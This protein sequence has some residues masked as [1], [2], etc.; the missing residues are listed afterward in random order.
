M[1]RDL[2][3]GLDLGT[4]A[5]KALAV[6]PVGRVVTDARADIELLQPA[7]GRAVIDADRYVDAA[8]A[9]LGVVAGQLDARRVA[10][11]AL[12]GAMHS[13]VPVDANDRPLTE[14]LTWADA[15]GQAQTEHLR[16]RTDTRGLHRR[17]GCPLRW[18]Y[19]APRL[20]YFREQ[21]SDI[22]AR[23]ARYVTLKD[24]VVHRLTGQWVADLGLMSTTGL[25]DLADR[26]F[27]DEALALADVGRDRLPR[28]CEPTAIIGPL[29]R[30]A[31]S[32]ARLLADLPVVAGSSDG[33]LA[34]LATLAGDQALA[35]TVG[36]SAAVRVN[37]PTPTVDDGE[38]T[39]CYL[40]AGDRYVRGGAI[41]NAGLLARWVA[42]RFYGD[43]P[44]DA[45]YATML[46]EAGD[47]A[48]GAAGVVMLPYLTGERTPIW[49]P[50]A[51]ATIHG[52]TL[53][54]TR[55]HIARAALEAVAFAVAELVDILDVRER[56]AAGVPLSGGIT[57][58]PIWC[59]ILADVLGAPLHVADV[60]DASAV[61]AAMVGHLAL[62]HV[63]TLDV[64]A[65][66]RPAGS[67]VTP[68]AAHATPYRD[69][70]ER[71][72]SLK[73]QLHAPCQH[74]RR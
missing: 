69:A 45:R 5:V 51:R 55:A 54:H 42:D 52:L 21:A 35:I 73:S 59:R 3:V 41:N 44:A 36:T 53:T 12:S 70:R 8:L 46:R 13:L 15:R 72:I 48:P 14:A 74:P 32:A 18:L 27:D 28:L 23:T 31:S 62:G 17:T 16:Q 67:T 61:G 22:D 30:E 34:N 40:I 64:G 43:A 11:L 7:P 47:V 65:R 68:T 26:D 20:R 37:C 4:T 29:T 1:S 38:L 6:D 63:D 71:Y 57:R 66:P 60:P 10:G 50:A 39:W 24:L 19:H 33:P 2:I 56:L 25:V 58:A 49:N 9:T